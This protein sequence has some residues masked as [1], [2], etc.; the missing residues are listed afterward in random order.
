MA[1]KIFNLEQGIQ[2]AISRLEAVTER[3]VLAAIYGAP[4][5]GKSYLIK[6]LEDHFDKKGE[7]LA[8]RSAGASFIQ[9]YTGMNR[10]DRQN[11]IY[12]FHCA[13]ERYADTPLPQDPNI[14]APEIAYKKIHL[15]IGIF[16]PHRFKTIEGDYDLIISNP[17]SRLKII[18]R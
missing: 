6:R 11:L 14:L 4:H 17:Q 3:P 7:L 1:Q 2:E 5:H 15:N 16:N 13:W 8:C 18:S 12:L 10:H 9:T